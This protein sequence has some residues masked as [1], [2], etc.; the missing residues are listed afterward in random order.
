MTR[1]TET[2]RLNSWGRVGRPRHFLATPREVEE[3]R[4]CLQEGARQPLKVLGVGLSRSYGLSG[5]NDGGAALAMRG[6]SRFHL[7]DRQ[8]GVLRA[9]AGVSLGEILDLI[10]P[11]GYFLPVI[12]GTRH[13]TLG[14][15]VAND[16]HGKNHHQAGTFGCHVRRLGLARSDGSLVELG[17]EDGTG[18]FEATIGGLGLT[19]LILWVEVALMPVGGALVEAQD[20]V[21]RDLDEFYAIAAESEADWAYTA[22]WVDCTGKA[23][24]GGRGIF[25]RARHAR[26]G[27]R[28]PVPRL[29]RRS[30]PV[31]LP[32][33]TLNA[34]TLRAFNALYFT[35]KARRA[36]PV[37]L[38]PYAPF[39]QPLD[40][41]GEWNRLYGA[42]GM[43]Q[44]QYA[45]PPAAAPAATRAILEV[46]A[47]SGEGSFLA[48]LKTFGPK[49]SPGLLS[50]PLEG[51]TLALDFA[52]KG[53]M[54]LRL[55]ERLDAIVRE[56]G[57]RLYPAK[58][59]RMPRAMFHEGYPALERFRDHVDPGCSSDF[60][61]RMA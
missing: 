8:R 41:I 38:G 36:G 29:A 37:R 30:I 4:A 1:F 9:D 13:V 25:S 20:V 60:W 19:G 21:F 27:S 26:E 34:F 6:L 2:T 33:A 24:R 16:V 49:P 53:D 40:T 59:G 39:F 56:A 22:A 7:F 12:P 48:V 14:G 28:S 61:R 54:T 57:G 58:D 46:I 47:R 52:N 10:V 44:Y 5:L 50:F 17:P 55:L 11:A 43:Y 35:S 32:S 23:G 42:R 51:T 45:I 31:D 3:A 15:A 18:L